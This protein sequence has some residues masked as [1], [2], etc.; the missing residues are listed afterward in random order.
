LLTARAHDERRARVGYA[1]AGD[2]DGDVGVGAAA[3]EPG[4]MPIWRSLASPRAACKT[5]VPSV[6][7]I[8]AADALDTAAHAIAA[9]AEKTSN[10]ARPDLRKH[11]AI[12]S[13]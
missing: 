9:I 8:V 13:D 11:D 3:G 2:A 10:S 5:A 4:E 6:T 12:A 1:E 7:R